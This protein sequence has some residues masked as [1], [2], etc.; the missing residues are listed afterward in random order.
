VVKRLACALALLAAAHGCASGA[1]PRDAALP[2]A[3]T[4]TAVLRAGDAVDVRFPRTPQYNAENVPV[5]GDGAVRLALVGDVA[6]AGRTPEQLREAVA[7]RY[8]EFLV[9]PDVAVAARKMGE[10]TVYVLGEVARP[11]PVDMPGPMTLLEAVAA[12][13]GTLPKS[14]ETG[15]VLVVRTAGGVR[16]AVAVDMDRALE[17]GS[18]PDLD[19]APRD[20]VYVPRTLIFR[21]DQWVDQHINLLIPQTG[22][23]YTR[24]LGATGT[25]GLDNSVTRVVP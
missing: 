5:G 1:A 17:A 20:V 3:R 21:I 7:A 25:L 6:A 18:A 10:R 8:A 9:D 23:N 14:A 11:G 12:A 4:A 2:D 16:K 19:L 22:V 24:A 13:G 15:S